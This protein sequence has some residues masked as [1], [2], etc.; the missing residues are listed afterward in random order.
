MVVHLGCKTFLLTNLVCTASK[1]VKQSSAYILGENIVMRV[2]FFWIFFKIIV[3]LLVLLLLLLLLL[4]FLL[5][6]LFFLL[7]L[8]VCLFVLGGG[9][10]RCKLWVIKSHALRAA[11]KKKKKIANHERSKPIQ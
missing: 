1:G 11:I 2:I 5:F 9:Y 7:L 4:L 3:L 10:Y 8:F 6:C